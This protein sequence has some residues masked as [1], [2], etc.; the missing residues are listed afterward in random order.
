[1]RNVP[2][3]FHHP[4]WNPQK[5]PE[6]GPS[7]AIE[8]ALHRHNRGHFRRCQSDG[9]SEQQGHDQQK[10]QCQSGSGRGKHGLEPEGSTGAI[11][12]QYS[13]EW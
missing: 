11:G 10:N 13:H 7:P 1:M 3:Q 5:V 9:D 6:R 2:V 12:E 4:H 8:A